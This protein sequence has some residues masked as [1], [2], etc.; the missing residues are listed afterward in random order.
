MTPRPRNSKRTSLARRSQVRHSGIYGAGVKSPARG[1]NK[2]EKSDTFLGET[3]LETI[4]DVSEARSSTTTFAATLKGITSSKTREKATASTSLGQVSISAVSTQESRKGIKSGKAAWKKAFKAARKVN[5]NADP[6]FAYLPKGINNKIRNKD[7]FRAKLKRLFRHKKGKA[8]N[9]SLDRDISVPTPKLGYKVGR[10]EPA[11]TRY[12]PQISAPRMLGESLQLDDTGVSLEAS[13]EVYAI[14]T[15][16]D[17]ADH[18]KQVQEQDDLRKATDL[19]LRL[20]GREQINDPLIGRAPPRP[21][22]A[23]FE[24]VRRL[25]ENVLQSAPL[26]NPEANSR[27]L[28]LSGQARKSGR[29]NTLTK[30]N[31]LD[32]DP[33]NPGNTQDS[34]KSVPEGTAKYT[35]TQIVPLKKSLRSNNQNSSTRLR[36]KL[37][38]SFADS[39]ESFII[40]NTESDHHTEDG[41]QSLIIHE[42]EEDNLTNRRKNNQLQGQKFANSDILAT[43][44]EATGNRESSHQRYLGKQKPLKGK[45]IASGEDS[46]KADSPVDNFLSQGT[47]SFE[48]SSLTR[49]SDTST[50]A[51]LTGSVLRPTPHYNWNSGNS[52]DPDS[53]TAVANYQAIKAENSEYFSEVIDLEEAHQE[54]M[55]FLKRNRHDHRVKYG[56]LQ[57][58]LTLILEMKLNYSC[59]SC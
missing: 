23:L 9:I 50:P 16:R 18:L 48:K 39:V 49:R 51:A 44:F 17:R 28:V 14:A 56:G 38:V 55:R 58:S 42:S 3:N 21:R 30:F 37:S 5:K 40:P 6:A 52:R 43:D 54:R 57:V 35:S 7:P 29:D 45:L 20:E 26:Q 11:P 4:G 36:P 19:R 46:I 22:R 59:W 8:T 41:L 34:S 33:R 2:R 25:T 12:V 24:P 53:L 13:F 32:Q 47:A 10:P 31:Q 1:I 15:E 27:E